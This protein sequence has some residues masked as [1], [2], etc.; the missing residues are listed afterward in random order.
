MEV[1]CGEKDVINMKIVKPKRIEGIDVF[2]ILYILFTLFLVNTNIHRSQ[3]LV[4]L[5]M[6]LMYCKIRFIK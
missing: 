5:F 6:I 3:L 4:N 1:L 2:A